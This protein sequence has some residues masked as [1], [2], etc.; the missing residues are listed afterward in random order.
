MPENDICAVIITFR[1][2]K[3]VLRN[4]VTLSLQIKGMVVVDNCSGAEAQS[5]LSAASREI[6]FALLQNDENLGIAAAFNLGIRWAESKGYQYVMLFDQ[7][8]RVTGGFVKTMAEFY[9]A[10]PRRSKMAV[11]APSYM[12][13]RLNI[14]LPSLPAQDGSLQIAMTSGSLMPIRIFQERGLFEES[15]FIDY[16]DYEYCLRVRS[17]GYLIEECR[18]AVLLHAPG[19]PQTYLFFGLVSHSG[20]RTTAHFADITSPAT[21]FGCFGNMGPDIPGYV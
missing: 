9:S 5:W 15:L 16:V 21:W 17:A 4:L 19:D 18:E 12:D 3:E 14:S 13:S 20:P 6:G 8:S 10:S 7:D 11:L 1:P 2:E